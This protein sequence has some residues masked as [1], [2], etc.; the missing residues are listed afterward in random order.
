VVDRVKFSSIAHRDHLFH[1]PLSAAKVERILDLLELPPGAR[2][3]D[4]GC[5]PAE[6][7]IR[8]VERFG[9]RGVGV[10][11]SPSAIAEARA[12]AA[13]RVPDADVTL[14]EA[15][16]ADAPL[17]P[18]EWDLAICIGST[19]LYGDYRGA[20]GALRALVRPGGALLVGD[21]FW[22]REPDPAFLA[23]LGAGREHHGT[24]ADNVAAGLEEGLVP[25]Y[26]AVCSEDDWD[27]YEGLYARAVET[28]ALAHPDD[29]DTPAMVAR[30]R[31]WRDAYLRWGRDTLGFALYLFHR[32]S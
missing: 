16:I 31:T 7:L 23:V 32:P 2:V 27:H 14:H 8:V 4:V 15:A 22:R 5:G 11:R 30:I 20:L 29:P 17:E 12:R 24:H 26:A 10:D 18:G 6:M 25:L 28:Y 19:H 21:L 13:R 1:S 3:V 9:A